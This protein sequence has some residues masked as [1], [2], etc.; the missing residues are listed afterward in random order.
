MVCERLHSSKRNWTVNPIIGGF[1]F[2][3]LLLPVAPEWPDALSN[4]SDLGKKPCA[5]IGPVTIGRG[6]R[7]T[8]N[9]G[10]LLH[11]KP[12]K[13]PQLHEL[14]PARA[15]CRQT[16]QRFVDR[17]QLIVSQ[18]GCQK[19]EVRF[20]GVYPAQ[21]PTVLFGA[22]ATGAIYKDTSHGLGSRRKKVR[23]VLPGRLVIAA[24]PQPRLVD[25]RGRLQGV[26]TGFP[27]HLSRS[28]L[29]QLIIYEGQQFLGRLRVTLT[30]PVQNDCNLMHG[31]LSIG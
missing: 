27:R 13:V 16:L 1:G 11:R 5:R 12:G 30:C 10:G 2:P 28:Q 14:S 9:V 23:S 21:S 19:I 29:A 8:Q 24:K 7:D 17:K 15:L 22:P 18:I 3:R 4:P 25:K 31:G 26:T 6:N 20:I